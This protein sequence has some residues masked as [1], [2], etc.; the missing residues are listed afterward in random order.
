MYTIYTVPNLHTFKY[1]C[2]QCNFAWFH[3]GI[4]RSFCIPTRWICALYISYVLEWSTRIFK[5]Y[6]NIGLQK[7]KKQNKNVRHGIHMFIYILLINF[8]N[9][10][11]ITIIA[12]HI[13]YH[14]KRFHKHNFCLSRG[15][16][17]LRTHQK[18]KQKLVLIFDKCFKFFIKK[19]M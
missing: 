7:I 19:F 9:T 1:K 6:R 18:H 4:Q 14:F 5:N 13:L 12:D 11:N 3:I 17:Y 2:V 16:S 15:T 10:N 8:K